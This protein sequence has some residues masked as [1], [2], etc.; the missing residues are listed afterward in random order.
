[1][2]A[3]RIKQVRLEKGITQGE[4]ARRVGL[5]QAEISRKENGKTATHVKDLEMFARALGVSP[6]E[7][8]D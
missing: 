5:S 8:I 3:I 6:A 1:M 2:C 4:L 7:L